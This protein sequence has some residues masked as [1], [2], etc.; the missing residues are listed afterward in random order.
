MSS[1][2]K[3]RGRLGHLPTRAGE[4]VRRVY[5]GLE[6]VL[7]TAK[8]VLPVT[9]V[10][11][12]D[13]TSGMHVRVRCEDLPQRWLFPVFS[14]H[15]IVIS[16]GQIAEN[17]PAKGGVVTSAAV[18]FAAPGSLSVI[19]TATTRSADQITAVALEMVGVTDYDFWT[20][21]CEDFAWQARTGTGHSP[22]RSA[23]LVVGRILPVVP[24]AIDFF[25][26]RNM[27]EAA[28]P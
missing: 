13:L 22:Q 24:R 5:R 28:Q 14:H 15:G 12:E 1:R 3:R 21:N 20:Y 27:D 25:M 9:R 8:L 6:S 19:P 23:V 18:D 7:Q 10:P 17:N 2:A 4:R 16:D 26:Q 11:V